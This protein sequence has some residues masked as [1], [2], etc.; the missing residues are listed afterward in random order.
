MFIRDELRGVFASPWDRGRAREESRALAGMQSM[1]LY[2]RHLPTPT[3]R[4][5]LNQHG[6]HASQS[7]CSRECRWLAPPFKQRLHVN[8]EQLAP[9]PHHPNTQS[10]AHE[11]SRCYV[12]PCLN[13][14]TNQ[15]RIRF[16]CFV[17]VRLMSVFVYR[18][19]CIVCFS[20][21]AI[22]ELS[23]GM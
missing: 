4:R 10:Q 15:M 1:F 6:M 2:P 23:Y 3:S 8:V 17:G 14:H 9:Y 5:P 16:T 18:V 13:A 21:P 7:S 20:I 19:L 22:Y 12:F 11:C